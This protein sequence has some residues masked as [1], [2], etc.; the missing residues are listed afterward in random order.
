MLGG[1]F[2]GPFRAQGSQVLEV[3]DRS[4]MS[5][6]LVNEPFKLGS[7]AVR[8]IGAVEV[9]RPGRVWLSSRLPET[10]R[11]PVACVSAG[12]MLYQPPSDH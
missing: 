8:A 11:L 2:L 5:G 3:A 1:V 6:S 4:S 9:L 10:E 7:F 12:L